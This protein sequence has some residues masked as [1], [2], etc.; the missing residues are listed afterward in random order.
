MHTD[1]YVREFF[2]HVF[3]LSKFT[4]V[5]LVLFVI[6]KCWMLLK[7]KKT[8]TEKYRQPNTCS[9][10]ERHALQCCAPPPPFP[11]LI[12]LPQGGSSFELGNSWLLGEAVIWPP[13]WKWTLISSLI[14][15]QHTCRGLL[16]WDQ[17]SPHSVNPLRQ[18]QRDIRSTPSLS[19]IKDHT[20]LISLCTHIRNHPLRGLLLLELN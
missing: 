17:P 20:D 18:E 5:I 1:M 8:C 4:T 16:L 14:K 10:C 7:E 9:R 19:V 15:Q 11:P 2:F 3:L 13:C 12:S 6:S